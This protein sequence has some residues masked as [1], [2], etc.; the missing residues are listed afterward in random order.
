MLEPQA[1]R[2]AGPP[3]TD[4]EGGI[5][6]AHQGRTR[7]APHRHRVPG[8]WCRGRRDWSC[9][10][11]YQRPGS[12]GGLDHIVSIIVNADAILERIA[13]GR[14]EHIAR[15]RRNASSLQEHAT[16]LIIPA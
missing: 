1:G 6:D 15:L 9:A 3:G 13:L 16:R 11:S 5:H 4:R 2:V 12:G 7:P 10:G 14:I 8:R